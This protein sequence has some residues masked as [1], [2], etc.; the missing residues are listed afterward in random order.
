MIP[1][2]SQ[3]FLLGPILSLKGLVCLKTI[4]PILFFK[5]I[6]IVLIVVIYAFFNFVN[7][8]ETITG[9]VTSEDGLLAGVNVMVQGTTYG[10]IT[11][12]DGKYTLMI[13][14]R[15]VTLVFSFVGY[16]TVIERVSNRSV[17]DVFMHPSISTLEE[18]VVTG[19]ST[20]SRK[21]ISG[22][23]SSVNPNELVTIPAN[24]VAAQLQGRA[25][26]VTVTNAGLP[27]GGTSVRIR[28]YGTISQYMNDPLYI[29]D[30]IP[31]ESDMIQSLNPQ[32]VESIQILKDA[33]AASIYGARAAHGVLIITTK[34]GKVTEG[35]ELAFNSYFGVQNFSNSPELLNPEG[36]ATVTRLGMENAGLD[37]NHPQYLLSDGS[38]GLPDYLIP[39]G[40]SVTLNGPVDESEYDL[41]TNPIVRAN[42]EGTNWFEEI[43]GPAIIQDYNLTV[44]GGSDK[45]KYAVS[46]GYFGQDGIVNHTGF[47]K[48]M[49]RVNTKFNIKEKVRIGETIGITYQLRQN[50]PWLAGH[51]AI[52]ESNRAPQIKPIYDIAGNYSSNKTP[53]IGSVSD[54]V[55][56]PVGDLDR[57]KDNIEKRFVFMGSFFLEWDI[58][59]DLTFK[60]S[61]NPMLN[62]T[63]ENKRFSPVAKQDLGIGEA[64]LAQYSWNEMNWTWYN[65]LTYQ[66]TFVNRHNLQLLVGSEAIENEITRFSA[67][68]EGF[69]SQDIDY[70]HLDAGEHLLD[71]SGY[72]SEWSLFS[73]FAKLDYNFDGK[74]LISA[75]VRRDGSSR[76]GKNNKYAV[77]PAFSAAWRLSGER[78]LE[79][80]NTIND[81]KIRASWGQTGNQNIG[82]YIIYDTFKKDIKKSGYDAF[83]TQNTAIVGFL[84]DA[85]GNPNARWE[86][87]TTA[88]IGLDITLFNNQLTGTIDFYKRTTTDMLM[89]VR[90]PGLM[91]Q[92]IRLWKNIGEMENKGIDF[93]LMYK[94][95]PIRDFKWDIGINI[96]QYK[97]KV[98]KLAEND[99]AEFYGHWDKG[100]QFSHII[101]VGKPIAT[102]WGYRILGIYQNEQ[103][104]LE[105]PKYVYGRWENDS[106]WVPDP[107][108]GVGRWNFADVDKNDSI[109]SNDRTS[110][111]SPHPDF[112]IGVPISIKYRGFELTMFWYGSFG[113]DLY[114]VNKAQTDLWKTQGGRNTQKGAR[115]LQSWGYPGLDNSQAILP[116]I[117]YAAPERESHNNSYLVEDGTYVRL[118]QILLGYTFNTS[119]WNGIGNFRI[120]LQGNNLLTWTNYL[121]L[122][123]NV[124]NDDHAL[125]YDYGYYPNVRSYMLGLNITFK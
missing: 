100:G 118:N 123:P 120:Y 16:E 41:E 125:G 10:N 116:Q 12:L 62:M 45:G 77:F 73:L 51:P 43:T 47:N 95:N 82:D 18:V 57:H 29:V 7:A 32:D 70:R 13:P 65:T 34:S 50:T 40:H 3:T 27:G 46:L 24:S 97:N 72:S 112:T 15:E 21:N 38:W 26:G 76:F 63:Y 83:G 67:Q 108:A 88:D 101:T 33:S 91:G 96:T 106:T 52:R 30:G 60:T 109:D 58:I 79:R 53:G 92:A 9:T 87:I 22:S 61:F 78:F 48:L 37:P 35:P 39:A 8:Q 81:L 2:N 5:T 124:F 55:G 90:Q 103:E 59:N 28:G 113:N 68:N 105:G 25:A 107:A 86:T 122:D 4:F 69:Y 98:T 85:F 111:G 75:T 80:L 84:P 1:N 102:F 17:I 56:N 14:D 74:Y 31:I 49:A 71:N 104:V 93:S 42:Q 6:R 94:S 115:L 44:N 89:Q 36:F 19:Y 23:I 20:Q 66:K 54:P 110:I 121:G 117:N 99:T 119:S 11:D 114:N 64:S